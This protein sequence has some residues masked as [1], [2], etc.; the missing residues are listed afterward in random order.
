MFERNRI[1]TTTAPHGQPVSVE[2]TFQDNEVTTGRLYVPNGRRLFD[3]LNGQGAFLEFTPLDGE[4]AYVARASIASVRLLDAPP[5]ALQPTTSE[6]P[7]AFDPYAVL[8]VTRAT[9]WNKVRDAYRKLSF[10]YHPDRYAQ[11]QLPGEVET[12]LGQKARAVNTA[13]RVLERAQRKHKAS[14]EAVSKPI[15]ERAGSATT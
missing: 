6:T 12:Y 4:P 11:A 9:D 2:L 14:S 7:N 13:F 15:Y 3:V 8:G 1:D 5:K 10:R